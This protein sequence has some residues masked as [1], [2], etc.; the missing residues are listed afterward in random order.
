[1]FKLCID[2]VST[3]GVPMQNPGYRPQVPPHGSN[4]RPVVSLAP[5]QYININVPFAQPP[6]FPVQGGPPPVAMQGVQQRPPMPMPGV[7]QGP[8][9][10]VPMQ[11]VQQAPPPVAMQGFPSPPAV[12]PPVNPAPPGPGSPSQQVSS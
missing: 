5:P 6:P 4:V 12:P 8:P 9:P 2:T 11:N 3:G 7:Q 1:M 10:P